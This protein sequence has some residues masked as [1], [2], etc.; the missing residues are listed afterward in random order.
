[1][2]EII[3]TIFYFIIILPFLI[4]QEGYK[5]FKKFMSHGRRWY[6][7]PYVLLGILVFLLIILLM[8]G[9]R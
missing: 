3:Q 1:M 2:G 9:Y 6:Y 5:M 8:Y 7:F 4:L